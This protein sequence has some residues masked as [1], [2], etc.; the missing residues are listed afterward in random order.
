MP[1]RTP[2]SLW[3]DAGALVA[4]GLATLVVLW[5]LGLT[6]RVLAGIDAYTY[7]T[8]YWAYRM[9]AFRSGQLPLWNPYLF[10]GVPF[11][12]NPQ[13]A[14]LYPLHWPLSWLDPPQALVWSAL[15]H[16][17]L[18]SAFTYVFGR[19]SLGLTR[20]AAFL[21]GLLF[22][23]GGYA[24]ARIENINQLNALA[25][26]P[27]ML[28]LYDE[29]VRCHGLRLRLRWVVAHSAVIALALLAGHTQAAFLDVAGLAVYACVQAAGAWQRARRST[30]ADTSRPWH[31]GAQRLLPLLAILP[32]GLLAAA[33]LLPAMELNALG[34]RTGGL[35]F[36]QAV[37]FSLRPRLL[38]QS[39]LPPFGGHLDGTFSSEGY[40]EFVGYLSVSGIVLAGLGI[41]A[42]FSRRAN[43][44]APAT[45]KSLVPRSEERQA[46]IALIW[47]AGA[48]LLLALGGYNPLYYLLWR[49]VP[50]F[51][52][53]RAPARWLALYALGMAGLAGV[54]LD[55]L[56]RSHDAAEAKTARP[57]SRSPVGRIWLPLVILAAA[58]AFVAS[59]QWPRW[60][61]MAGWL[62]AGILTAGLW[63]VGRTRARLRPFAVATLVGLVLAELWLGARALPFAQA[64][65]P[66][67]MGLRSAPATLLAAT[68][69]QPPAGR[70]RYLSLSDIRFDP[71]DLA[72]LRVLEADR[73]PGD[74]VERFVR[75]AKQSEVLA[76]NLSLLWRL[77]AVDGYDGGVLPLARYVKL[78]S[79]F[80]PPD[81][82][83]PD[84]RLREQ[85]RQ[86]P[87]GRLLDLTGARYVITDKQNDLWAGDVYYDLEQAASLEPGQT[88]TLDL[89]AYP[90]FSA[91]SLGIVSYLPAQPRTEDPV[92]EFQLL[93]AQGRQVTVPIDANSDTAWSGAEAVS[94]RATVARQWPDW[95]G[96]GRD[97]LAVKD[98][99]TSS[100]CSETVPGKPGPGPG[101]CSFTPTTLRITA[102]PGNSATGSEP[103]GARAPG[104]QAGIVVRGVSLID[105]RTGA[106]QSIT[107]SPDGDFRRIY[108]GDVKIYERKSAPGRAW[109][110]HN[111]PTVAD[112]EA[113]LARLADPAFD[114]RT[115][116]LI[117]TTDPA[118]SAAAAALKGQ[119]SDSETD[120]VDVAAFEP[121][122][123]VLRTNSAGPAVLVLADAIYPGWQ[124]SVDGR[125]AQ[126]L[127]AN[128][129]FRGVPLGPGHH[130]VTLIYRPTSWA[131]G[132]I[133]SLAGV[134]IL[135]C[136]LVV[137]LIY[138]PH[139][140]V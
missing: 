122:R 45:A 4:L 64:T 113:A 77:P 42:L 76:P 138:K 88:L 34:L 99:A 9:A 125:P 27:A 104:S 82:L 7:F 123:V 118:V 114:P 54:G 129:M 1:A 33:Q 51:G 52:L 61:A 90:P 30:G 12:A 102:L 109:L 37:S 47:L 86:I 24:L 66:A 63:W 23:L 83:S 26:F 62:V 132:L 11:L 78:Q 97:Y 32:A 87:P 85:L 139:A 38:A 58:V 73:L 117:T 14:V 59:Q 28:W 98:L 134:A 70:D 120:R 39:L 100:D 111:A 127:T 75:A 35:A 46:R 103:T 135:A 8:P 121:E 15:L 95:M 126:L 89:S 133:L 136:V 49:L 112:D 16:I 10:L 130:E 31:A 19:R 101:N 29:T 94:G 105:K 65:A 41:V 43:N 115:T 108:S 81:R 137:T 6:N 21:A 44:E 48:G 93:D 20:P 68:A 96:P 131:V 13:A 2:R 71:G 84:G 91:T 119:L 60:T 55:A 79:L 69:G 53:F 107:V 18:A 140:K 128:F 57:G 67:A 36:R 5:P 3:Q 17:W 116:A 50:G 40:A 110:V 56:V 92:A 124:A 80:L 72:E 74:A 25:W 106:H 22:G